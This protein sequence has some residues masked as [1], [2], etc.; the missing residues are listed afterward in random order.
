MKTPNVKNPRILVGVDGSPD[1]LRAVEYA[2]RTAR[3][4]GG[5]LQLVNAVDD[6][7]LA[8]AWG[9][10][11]D[12]DVLEEVGEAA[13][14]EATDR[15][16]G[17]GFEASRMTGKV[18]MGNP[19]AVLA[20]LSAD[21][22]LL[23]VGR[24]A[25]GGL[26][27]MFVGSTSVTLAATAKCPMVTISAAANPEETGPRGVVAVGVSATMPPA[28][29]DWAFLEA[30]TRSVV[31]RALHVVA[32]EPRAVAEA[33]ADPAAH[34]S[35]RLERAT[36]EVEAV[37]A[38]YRARH[39]EVDVEV[40]VSDGVPVTEL[41]ARSGSFSLLVLGIRPTALAGVALGG[42]VRGVM[43]HAHCPVGTFH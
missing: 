14:K 2:M 42:V 4:R 1:G 34:R 33:A 16:L 31:L 26:E 23:V 37:L 3:A 24:R 5:S 28:A 35:Q 41:V 18:V 13:I 43:A 19:A 9:V 7:V 29:L 40:D 8:G 36:K 38:P 12:P 22:D 21:S 10:M 32:P 39:P 27:R 30:E 6:A 15:L 17:H 20:R 11:Y 25:V